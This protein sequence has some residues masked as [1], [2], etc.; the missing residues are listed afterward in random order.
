MYYHVVSA[1][2]NCNI[3]SLCCGCDLGVLV[4]IDVAMSLG[5]AVMKVSV[6]ID[7]TQEH[8]FMIMKVLSI[9]LNLGESD[10]MGHYPFLIYRSRSTTT[11]SSICTG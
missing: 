5:R 8:F 4:Y 3:L 6:I 10:V 7:E 1:R 9:L 2:L 11:V